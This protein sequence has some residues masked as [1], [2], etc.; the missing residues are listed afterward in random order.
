[1][2]IQFDKKWQLNQDGTF[3]VSGQTAAY[4]QPDIKGPMP[5]RSCT[6]YVA[7]ARMVGD[8]VDGPCACDFGHGEAHQ[9]RA[10]DRRQGEDC[11]HPDSAL[12]LPKALT[13]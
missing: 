1:M 9:A 7:D 4:P 12:A 8:V 2:V 10:Q 6:F 3:R 11:L 13:P 5:H